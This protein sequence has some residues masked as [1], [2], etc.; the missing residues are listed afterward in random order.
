MATGALGG[1][2]VLLSS[3]ASSIGLHSEGWYARVSL[4]GSEEMEPVTLEMQRAAHPSGRGARVPVRGWARGALHARERPALR[5]RRCHE[6]RGPGGGRW[7]PLRERLGGGS[8]WKD[9]EGRVSRERTGTRSG[10]SR[11]GSKSR[12]GGSDGGLSLR[13]APS[14]GVAASGVRELWERGVGDPASEDRTTPKG[15]LK[16]EASYGL[17]EFPGDALRHPA[18]R[19][20]TRAGSRHRCPVRGSPGARPAVGRKIKQ[21]SCQDHRTRTRRQRPLV[22]VLRPEHRHGIPRRRKPNLRE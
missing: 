10:A 2:R 17:A 11:A 5:C 14:W 16:A 9:G 19:A 18:T 15:L 7:V 22:A 12:R 3:T 8:R 1:R 13:L 21:E 4:E 20:G 6:R